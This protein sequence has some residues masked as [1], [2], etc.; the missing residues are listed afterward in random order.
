MRT[1]LYGEQKKFKAKI[2]Y[3]DKLKAPFAVLVGEDEVKEGLLSVKDMRSGQQRKLSMED[4]A[5]FIKE[6]VEKLNS[7]AVIKE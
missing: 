2:G 4:A 7:G 3:A 5:A 6:S 1:Q